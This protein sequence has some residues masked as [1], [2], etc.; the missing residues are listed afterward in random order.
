MK[1]NAVI[2]TRPDVPDVLFILPS[3]DDAFDFDLLTAKFVGRLSNSTPVLIESVRINSLDGGGTGAIE[4]NG[5]TAEAAAITFKFGQGE[6]HRKRRLFREDKVFNLEDRHL[7][8][9]VVFYRPY[10]TVTEVGSFGS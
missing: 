6:A 2:S 5:R 10:T 1:F 3:A 8:L 7:A 9:A 4:A